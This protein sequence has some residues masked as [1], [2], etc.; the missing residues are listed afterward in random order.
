MAWVP[1]GWQPD[2]FQPDGWQPEAQSGGANSCLI[3]EFKEVQISNDGAVV[4]VAMGQVRSQE[5]LFGTSTQSLPFRNG[6]KLIRVIADA[7]VYLV[8]GADPTATATAIRL[9][10]NTVEYF[11]VEANE[12]VACYDGSS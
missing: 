2:G 1:D 11:G 3:T 10:A 7:D 8:F 5:V 4:P 9:P 12:I 6:V